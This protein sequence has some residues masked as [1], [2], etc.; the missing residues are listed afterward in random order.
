[1]VMYSLCFKR[2]NAFF[3]LT[4]I[5]IYEGWEREGFLRHEV[6]DNKKLV[7]RRFAVYVLKMS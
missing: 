3:E 2:V 1:M 4:R 6:A 7:R 5:V